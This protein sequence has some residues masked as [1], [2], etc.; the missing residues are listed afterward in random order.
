MWGS[1][2]SLNSSFASPLKHFL[3]VIHQMDSWDNSKG[4]REHSIQNSRFEETEEQRKGRGALVQDGW[5]VHFS[6]FSVELEGVQDGRSLLPQV[7]QM[8]AVVGQ[9]THQRPLSLRKRAFSNLH[10]PH[11]H[12]AHPFDVTGV[13][14]CLLNFNSSSI[15]QETTVIHSIDIHERMCAC[16]RH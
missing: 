4:N 2:G 9:S 6:P 7:P 8:N 14:H 13:T 11:P 10:W 12:T 16:R 15:S 5:C 1:E 3:L